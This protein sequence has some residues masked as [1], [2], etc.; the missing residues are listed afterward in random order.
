MTS[1]NRIRVASFLAIFLAFP[2][3]IYAD[4]GKDSHIQESGEVRLDVD[5]TAYEELARLFDLGYPPATVMMHAI[6]TG[7]SL[8]D[9]LYIAVK[10][11]VSRAQEFYDTAESLVPALPGWVCQERNDR[12]RY[13]KA[14][15]LS[16]LGN[17]PTI[18]QGADVF[19][20]Q[21]R[22]VVPF[23]DWED[24]R[25]HMT[26]SVAELANLVSDNRWYVAGKDDG[27]PLTAPNRP[28]FVSL[29]KDNGSIVVDSGIDRIRRAQQQGVDRLPV[30]LV[31]ND[32]DQRPITDF[33]ADVTA[34][35]IAQYFYSEG[36]ELTAVPEWQVGD[37]HKIASPDELREVVEIPKKEDIPPEKLA[38]AEQKLR[39]NGMKLPEPL[40][41]TLVRS[42]QGRAWI[43]D[44]AEVVA[45][46]ELGV[47]ALPVVFFY[48]RI[49]R[50]PCGEP[51]RCED[52]LCEAATSAGASPKVCESNDQ[53]KTNTAGADGSNKGIAAPTGNALGLTIDPRLY[54][55]LRYTQSQC[56][57]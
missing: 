35:Q 20:N 24:G 16:D 34:G 53:N 17:Q 25:V 19:F 33:P 56:T 21:N 41:L 15:K 12:D 9:I 31:Y 43:N 7:M 8:N 23:P 13:I 46:D 30:V 4:L 26:A 32:I 36:L 28:I 47:K 39:D 37:Y 22:R 52:M 38:A 6:T 18:R 5:R 51:A 29:Y 44:P 14:V 27:T 54:E 42:G 45:A 57:S 1:R 55:G 3:T 50:T 40:L 48:H 49:D 10:S 2:G 11:D